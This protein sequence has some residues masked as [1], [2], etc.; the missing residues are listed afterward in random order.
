MSTSTLI[1]AEAAHG[2]QQQIVLS[3]GESA[4]AIGV[5]IKLDAVSL[6]AAVGGHGHR[7]ET[8]DLLDQNGDLEAARHTRPLS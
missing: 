2:A 8:R 3:L 5:E 4:A 7:L 6:Q 1:E